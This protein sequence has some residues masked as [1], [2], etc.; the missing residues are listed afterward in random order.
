MWGQE[1]FI[2]N[3]EDVGNGR[4]VLGR[5]PRAQDEAGPGRLALMGPTAAWN[6]VSVVDP[7][8]ETAET[9]TSFYSRYLFISPSKLGI[10]LEDEAPGEE[11]RRAAMAAVREEISEPSTLRRGGVLWA[12]AEFSRKNSSVAQAGSQE[13]RE[14]PGA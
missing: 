9:T 14:G 13:G 11:G 5:R 10:S 6:L 4:R 1:H 12:K 7:A 2:H 3:G 8:V